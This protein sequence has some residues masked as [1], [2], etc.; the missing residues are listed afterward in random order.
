VTSTIEC[1]AIEARS[2]PP[3][4]PTPI[5]AVLN[6][7]FFIFAQAA[8]GKKVTELSKAAFLIKSLLFIFLYL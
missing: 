6:L 2:L 3:I 7:P 4:P 1:E 8:D 5:W